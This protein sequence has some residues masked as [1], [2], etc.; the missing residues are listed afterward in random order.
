M[1]VAR[2]PHLC[3][4]PKVP[5]LHGKGKGVQPKHLHIITLQ[6][7]ATSRPQG[8]HGIHIPQEN[9][10]PGTRVPYLDSRDVGG[11]ARYAPFWGPC[12][13]GT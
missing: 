12:D 5:G 11:V 4:Q 2:I 10:Q 1:H 9:Q 3:H 6:L 8:Q 7:R 13:E